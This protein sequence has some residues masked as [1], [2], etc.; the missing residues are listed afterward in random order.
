MKQVLGSRD[1][2]SGKKDG[3][4]TPDPWP[5]APETSFT[6]ERAGTDEATFMEVFSMLLQEHKEVGC[7]PLDT[8]KAAAH[9]YRILEMGMTFV[10][11]DA[12]GSAIGTLSLKEVEFW[13]SRTSALFDGWFYVPPTHRNGRVG[14]E[15]LKAAAKEGQA[16]GMLVFV[17]RANP[18]RRAKQTTTTLMAE[19]AGFLPVG[20]LLKV[21][22]FRG[23]GPQ[24][25]SASFSS[26][27]P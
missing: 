25:D 18:N 10:A 7:A 12:S 21:S 9:C 17:M 4:L 22:G 16:R 2:V 27:D 11:R 24:S 8:D 6:I 19:M 23:Q 5:L 1:Q 3:G 14:V 26:P 15:L 13:Y 20:Y